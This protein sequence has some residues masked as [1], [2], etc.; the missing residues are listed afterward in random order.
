MTAVAPLLKK[1]INMIPRMQRLDTIY[2]GKRALSRCHTSFATR[3]TPHNPDMVSNV[4]MR[5]SFH[6]YAIPAS[7]K[8]T[9]RHMTHAVKRKRPAGLSD[10]SQP[11]REMFFPVSFLSQF[12]RRTNAQKATKAKNP[13]GRLM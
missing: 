9:K 1:Q 12:G 7:C 3:P 5:T 2:A 13:M 10:L 4:M 8:A 11:A 6:W